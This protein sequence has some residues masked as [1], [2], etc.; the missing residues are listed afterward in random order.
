[1]D[2]NN[3]YVNAMTK[4]LV[5]GNIEKEKKV[6]TLREF[7]MIIQGILDHDKIGHVFVVGIEFDQENAR[8][9]QLFFKGIDTLIFEKKDI[10]G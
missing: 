8:E 2:Q 1:M 6:L 10:F 4:P 5:T 9:K 3:Q 7:D